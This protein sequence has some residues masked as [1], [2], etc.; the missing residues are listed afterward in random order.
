MS[1]FGAQD[2]RVLHDLLIEATIKCSERG[3]IQSAKWAAELAASLANHFPPEGANTG[4]P[5]NTSTSNARE[6]RL[7]A[8]ELPKYLL[9]KSYFD[10][11]EFDRCS[12]VFLK[13]G[14]PQPALPKA[15]N[16]SDSSTKLPT[17]PWKGKDKTNASA[18]HNPSLTGSSLAQELSNLSEKAIFLALYAKYMAGE[19]RKDEE[20]EMILGPADRG[21]AVNRE[22]VSITQ[23]LE[24][25]FEARGPDG[26][27]GGWLEYLYGVCLAR[28]KNE[29]LAKQW[30]VRSVSIYQYNWSAWQELN[31]IDACNLAVL[32]LDENMP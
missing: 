28:G 27:S 7:E 29:T 1:N 15:T 26:H 13:S 5:P 31:L 20:N 8:Q 4:S 6:L 2:A 10:C 22:L 16:V 18:E 24:M 3:L 32:Y 14:L 25:H 23:A 21:A 9:A 19:K 12:H 11:R 30:L 17:S